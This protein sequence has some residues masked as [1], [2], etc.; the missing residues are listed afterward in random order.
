MVDPT[1][2]CPSL[3]HVRSAIFVSFEGLDGAGKTTQI[4]RLAKYLRDVGRNVRIVREPG[5]T[6][7]GEQVRN[8]LLHGDDVVPWAEASL[9]AAARAQL[10][11]LEI[12]PSL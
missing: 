1:T 3:R 12:R 2:G 4:K 11:E 7:L 6:P 8:M 5:G 10:V 9:F